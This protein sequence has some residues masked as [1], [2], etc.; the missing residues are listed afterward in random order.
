MIVGKKKKF[1][2]V[3]N[4][5]NWKTTF[6]FHQRKHI[7]SLCGT[8]SL[9]PFLSYWRPDKIFQEAQEY[10]WRREIMHLAACFVLIFPLFFPFPLLFDII[11]QVLKPLL[12]FSQ[13]PV[14][15]FYNK[16]HGLVIACLQVYWICR[17]T[18]FLVWSNLI[19]PGD[20]YLPFES[21]G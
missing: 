18:A 21:N 1:L 2:S 20:S 7:S 10:L 11:S 8:I 13:S 17:S 4:Q 6:F 3:F 12:S 19:I 9:V 5:Y 15:F 16:I 14:P